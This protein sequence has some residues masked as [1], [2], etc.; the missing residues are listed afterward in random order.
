MK[1]GRVQVGMRVEEKSALQSAHLDLIRDMNPTALKDPLY[2]R[3]LLT[4]DEYEMLDSKPT[5][6]SKNTFITMLLPRKGASAFRDFISC[7]RETGDENS[8]HIDLANDLESRL[9]E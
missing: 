7:L 5:T 6:R 2:N 4:L 3:K 9:H 1:A 8:A